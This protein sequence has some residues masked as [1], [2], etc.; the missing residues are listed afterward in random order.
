MKP[1]K[2]KPKSDSGTSRGPRLWP[3]ALLLFAGAALFW[4]PTLGFGFVYDDRTQ[5]LADRY[6]HEGRN[7]WDMLTFRVLGQDVLDRNRPVQLLSLMLDSAVWGLRPVGYHLTNVLLHA[8]NT[9]LLF[10]LILR[11]PAVLGSAKH[12]GADAG[13]RLG[14][15]VGAALF[16][17]HPVQVEAVC[18][19][20]FREDLLVTFF[21]LAGMLAALTVLADSATRARG[22]PAAEPATGNRHSPF[23]IRQSPW[24]AGGLMLLAFLLA[25]GAKETGVIA[26]PLLVVAGWLAVRSGALPATDGARRR[27]W[28]WTGAAAAVVGL[29]FAASGWLAPHPSLI[30]PDM[31]PVVDSLGGWV[32]MQVRIWALE[33]RHLVWPSGYSGFY[34]PSE[35]YQ[36]FN[37][38]A[39]AAVLVAAI[40]VWLAGCRRNAVAWFGLAWAVLAMLPVS[41]IVPIFNP[42]A[43]RY[44][45]LPLAGLCVWLAA[46]LAR[47]WAFPR[48]QSLL[49][50]LMLAVSA[51]FAGAAW[52]QMDVWRDQLTLCQDMARRAPTSPQVFDGLGYAWYDAGQLQLAE[53]SWIRSL[54]LS[55]GRRAASW[56][57]LAMLREKFGNTAGADEAM[58]HAIAADPRYADI[59]QVLRATEI[60]RPHAEAMR[61]ICDRLR[62]AKW[63][64][65]HPEPAAP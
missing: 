38:P 43:D 46:V 27:W 62:R 44:L 4:L 61:P 24:L 10:L 32:E 25:V 36:A 52:L 55:Q 64:K 7:F 47:L 17:L 58:R 20:S 65:E 49:A 2:S 12:A 6:I 56:A 59:D 51:V 28:L 23:V 21:L 45:Y 16:A 18:A 1:R 35:V 48:M 14:A 5:I 50:M 42:I 15:L 11:L 40:A 33:I 54:Q 22:V 60:E 13:L 8:A 34:T 19:P 63:L 53:Q 31:R 39:A 37:L 29:F 3:W 9:A 57:G 41:N 30:F 26:P